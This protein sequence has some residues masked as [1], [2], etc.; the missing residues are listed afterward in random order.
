MALD[1]E[2][3]QTSTNK[4]QKATDLS[5]LFFLIFRL[6]SWFLLMTLD[7]VSPLFNCPPLMLLVYAICVSSN[8]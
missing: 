3:Q 8:Y 5:S 7:I 1:P 2:T 4:Y 6:C